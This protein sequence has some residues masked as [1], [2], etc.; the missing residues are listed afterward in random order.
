MNLEKKRM[1]QLM[2]YLGGC[3]NVKKIIKI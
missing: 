3:L 2:K 1:G